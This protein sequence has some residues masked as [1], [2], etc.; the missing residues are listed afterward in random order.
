MTPSPWLA[1]PPPHPRLPPGAGVLTPL[2][3][4]K[5]SFGDMKPCPRS[6]TITL[7]PPTTTDNGGARRRRR[8]GQ[9]EETSIILVGR[10]APRNHKTHLPMGIVEFI[11]LP[12]THTS[13]SF[14][15]PLPLR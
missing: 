9:G 15:C 4:R 3:R 8:K 7:S 12:T 14:N 11:H 2:T 13:S 6:Q 10:M 5:L 1:R